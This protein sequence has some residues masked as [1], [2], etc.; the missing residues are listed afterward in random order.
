MSNRRKDSIQTGVVAFDNHAQVVSDA[1]IVELNNYDVD[2]VQ[3]TSPA[4]TES[5]S[6]DDNPVDDD[7]GVCRKIGR[8]VY[9]LLSSSVSSLVLLLVIYT[10]VGAAILHHTEYDRE[11]QM[12]AELDDIRR[13]VVAE[14]VN[15]TTSESRDSSDVTLADTVEALVVEYSDARQSLNP[16]SKSPGWTF[17]GAIYFC[18]TVYTTIGQ[19]SWTFLSFRLV[20]SNSMIVL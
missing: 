11:L 1:S 10:L 13:R 20:D 18:G 19:C 2:H 6:P 3:P 7:V 8:R 16:G 17:T 5:C 9:Q 15:L 14:I 12:H 4:V